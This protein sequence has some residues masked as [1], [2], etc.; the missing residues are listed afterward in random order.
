MENVKIEVT[1]DEAKF[2]YQLVNKVQISGK[3]QALA[4]VAL[5]DKIGVALPVEK[6]V[7]KVEEIKKV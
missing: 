2:L 7:K 4:L 5:I 3:P 1:V 6:E